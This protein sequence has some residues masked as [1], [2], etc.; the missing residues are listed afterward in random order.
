MPFTTSISQDLVHFIK[1]NEIQPIDARVMCLSFLF[2]KGVALTQAVL[3][4][5]EDIYI[6]TSGNQPSTHFDIA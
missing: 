6:F 5:A 2:D 3:E 4:Q 1:D